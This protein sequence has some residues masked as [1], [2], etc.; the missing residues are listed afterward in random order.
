MRL[1]PLLPVIAAAIGFTV[2]WVVKPAPTPAAAPSAGETSTVSPKNTRPGRD[3]DRT[4]S[5]GRN[6]KEVHATDF[7]LADAAEKGPK[8]AV[9]GKLGRLAEALGLSVDQQAAIT[10]AIE[11]ARAAASDKVPILTDLTTRGSEIE[12]KLKELLTPEQFAKFLEMRERERDNLIESRARSLLSPAIER[13]DLSP[14]Q[15]EDLLAR[16]RLYQREEIQEIPATATLLLGN[17]LLP[18]DPKDIGIDGVLALRQMENSGVDPAAT[19][20]EANERMLA[21]QKEALERKL[22]CFDGI[23]TAGQ[24]GQYQ[25]YI[26]E[27]QRI[28]DDVRRRAE[29]KR[30]AAIKQQIERQAAEDAAALPDPVPSGED[31]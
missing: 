20:Q 1:Q 13:I 27:H 26:A 18:T 29:E 12:A 24:M 11:A 15:R 7:P 19:A 31:E 4:N 6:P 22:E 25:A 28:L 3:A 2:A 16:L 9:E 23:L 30:A 14:A 21:R 10:A 5:A 8:T 17:S